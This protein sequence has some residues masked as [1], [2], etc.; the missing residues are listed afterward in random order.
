M[1]QNHV[2]PSL[3]LYFYNYF[4]QGKFIKGRSVFGIIYVKKLAQVRFENSIEK[5]EKR[6]QSLSYQRYY[7]L[8]TCLFLDF[9]GFRKTH[10]FILTAQVILKLFSKNH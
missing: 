5:E 3:S 7:F 4:E 2:W 1:S 10:S 6:L 8:L 9:W